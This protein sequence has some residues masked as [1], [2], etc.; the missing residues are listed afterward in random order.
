MTTATRTLPPVTITARHPN[1]RTGRL[2]VWEAKT[3]GWVFIRTEEPGT[4]WYAEATDT[5]LFATFTSLLAARRAAA[6]DLREVL[7]FNARNAAIRTRRLASHRTP[8]RYRCGCGGLLTDTPD[9]R[10]YLH[11]DGCT[12]CV[13]AD[14]RPG[15]AA[16]LATDPRDRP[17]CDLEHLICVDPG[18]VPCTRCGS[19]PAWITIDCDCGRDGECCGC[20]M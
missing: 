2:E 4:P 13:P 3:P 14:P 9:G 11:V 10:G 20:C 18:P 5:H 19:A 6:T 12:D 17:R 1:L 7:H 8:A 15:T 16:E